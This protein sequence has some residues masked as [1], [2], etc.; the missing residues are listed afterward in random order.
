MGG[1]IKFHQLTLQGKKQ[2]HLQFS[3]A[4]NPNNLPCTQDIQALS[5]SCQKLAEQKRLPAY[6]KSKKNHFPLPMKKEIQKLHQCRSGGSVVPNTIRH[7]TTQSVLT[8][9]SDILKLDTT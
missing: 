8:P 9:C 5:E 3:A 1:K 2:K 7:Y 4:L 6:S